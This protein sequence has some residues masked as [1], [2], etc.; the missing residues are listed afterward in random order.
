MSFLSAYLNGVDSYAKL[1][2]TC[3]HSNMDS[4]KSVFLEEKKSCSYICNCRKN[5]LMN[6]ESDQLLIIV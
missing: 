6:L 3:L 1:Q 4:F 5:L 2:L